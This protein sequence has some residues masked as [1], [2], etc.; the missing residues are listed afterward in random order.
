MGY[1]IQTRTLLT[2][3]KAGSFSEFIIE[4]PIKNN[5]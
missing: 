1:D 3:P 4:I 2:N 5:I